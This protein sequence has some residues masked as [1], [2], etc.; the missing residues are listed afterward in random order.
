MKASSRGHSQYKK[1]FRPK[2]FLKSDLN[3]QFE[4]NSTPNIEFVVNFEPIP[5]QIDI[6]GEKFY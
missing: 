3:V 2:F 6:C 5:S 1:S 4:S